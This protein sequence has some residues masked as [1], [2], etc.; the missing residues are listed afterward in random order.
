MAE[1]GY[2]INVWI[3]E[4]RFARLQNSPVADLVKEVFAGL[5]VIQV[6]VTEEQKDRILKRFPSAKCDTATTRTIEL[7]PRAAK[8]LL[9]DLVAEN[10]SVEVVDQFLSAM[11]S[12]P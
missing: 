3:N 12:R 9:F 8:D 2:K 6:P 7:L 10:R 4:E 11:E 5:K 1:A